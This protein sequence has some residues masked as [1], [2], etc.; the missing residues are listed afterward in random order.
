M[1]GGAAGLAMLCPP[2]RYRAGGCPASSTRPRYPDYFLFLLRP[3]TGGRR[4]AQRGSLY[5]LSSARLMMRFCTS[6]V[7]SPMSMNGASRYR[8]SISYSLE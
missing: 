6:E 8:R 7:P 5:S 1:P 2:G 3:A 4:P